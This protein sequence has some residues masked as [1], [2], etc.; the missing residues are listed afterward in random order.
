VTLAKRLF[1]YF[2]GFGIGLILLF[3]FL[4]GKKASCDYLPTARTLKNIRQKPRVVPDEVLSKLT[5]MELDT[6]AIGYLLTH[7]DVD[8]KASDTSRD[9]CNLYFIHG[10]YK[11]RSLLLKVENCN[12]EAQIK[13]LE[14]IP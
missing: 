3:F 8:F 14:F 12:E 7:G 10:I 5:N 9:S 11:N 2:G 1:F 6:A 13:S 4:G